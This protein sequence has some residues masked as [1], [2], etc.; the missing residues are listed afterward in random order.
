MVPPTTVKIA[1]TPTTRALPEIADTRP[2][3]DKVYREINQ[4]SSISKFFGD[5]VLQPSFLDLVRYRLAEA[6]PPHLRHARLELRQADIGFWIPLSMSST[7]MPYVPPN[8]PAVAAIIGGLVGYGVVY[9]LKRAAANEYGVAY[10]VIAIDG[11]SVPASEQVLI[12]DIKADEA[13][14]QAVLRAL[15]VL[16]ERVA[17]FKPVEG[18]PEALVPADGGIK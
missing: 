13:V 3:V 17:A 5:D 10:I 11:E 8:V 16:A 7:G 18:G 12:K 15:D 4:S 9:G 14:R 2:D 1:P 6:L